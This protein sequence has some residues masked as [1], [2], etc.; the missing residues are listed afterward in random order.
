[1]M[2]LSKLVPHTVKDLKK[3]LEDKNP[4]AQVFSVYI[5]DLEGTFRWDRKETWKQWIKKQRDTAN[6]VRE[7]RQYHNCGN[8][9][10]GHGHVRPRPDGILARC[11]GP[12]ICSECALEKAQMEK[13]E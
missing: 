7:P 11:G 12:G 1:M 2:D 3:W 13:K 4:D 10:T 5:G 8:S 9:N 6:A